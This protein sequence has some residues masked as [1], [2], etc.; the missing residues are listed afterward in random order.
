[1]TTELQKHLAQLN[2][3]KVAWVAEDPDNRFTG[4]YEEDPAYWAGIG[5]V[6]LD[7]FKRHELK[8]SIWE[9]YKD[10]H[11]V[12]PRWINFDT[13][14]TEDMENTIDNL[15]KEYE[16][17]REANELANQQELQEEAKLCERFG[18]DTETLVKWGVLEAWTPWRNEKKWMD[19]DRQLF[20]A[21]Q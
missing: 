2:A 20:Y 5:V 7:D 4:L 6:T 9:M 11:G 3:N 19:L 18:T 1:M 14:T 8:I 16:V 12:R 10:V 21:E 15:H 17:Q 13:M